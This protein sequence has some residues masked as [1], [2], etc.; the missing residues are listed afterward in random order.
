MEENGIVIGGVAERPR[1][2]G[3]SSTVERL[4]DVACGEYR[5][6]TAQVTWAGT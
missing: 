3:M 4:P 5:I 2:E 1:R 6:P